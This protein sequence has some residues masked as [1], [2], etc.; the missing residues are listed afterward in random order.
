MVAMLLS[1][2][3]EHCYHND[4]L[5]KLYTIYEA[6]I[7]KHIKGQRITQNEL[8]MALYCHPVDSGGGKIIF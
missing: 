6:F 3:V 7:T 4:S 8:R 1:Y 5:E 2:E